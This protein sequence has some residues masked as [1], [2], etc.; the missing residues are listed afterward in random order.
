MTT[1]TNLK[2]NGK[3]IALLDYGNMYGWEKDLNLS[4]SPKKIFKYLKKLSVDST[5]FYY[6]TD[7][8]P[9]SKLFLKTIKSMGYELITK[10]VKYITIGKIGSNVIKKRK[11]D[12]DVEICITVH[13]AIEKFRTFIFFSG[14]G[15][16]A[17]LYQKLIEL[18]K[19]VIVI[20]T[21]GHLGKEIWDIPKGVFKVQF[22]QLPL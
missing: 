13:E 11:C 21:K 15:D 18:H 10:P 8:N 1:K 20:Y 22:D 3:C 12:F 4:I 14:D 16:F 6:G 5:C 2:I 19:Q 17:P 9:K 7:N